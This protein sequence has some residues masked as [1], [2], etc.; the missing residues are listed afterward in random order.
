MY[1][2]TLGKFHS[3]LIICGLCVVLGACS[4][5]GDNGPDETAVRNWP[6]IGGDYGNRRFSALDQI[7]TANIGQVGGAWTRDLDGVVLGEPVV[8]NGRLFVATATTAYAL[9]GTTG[10]V[11]WSF[12]L[13][14][15]V[16][17]SYRGVGAGDEKI[18][19]G[20]GDGRVLALDEESGEQ[21]WISAPDSGFFPSG[22]SY[23]DGLVVGGLVMRDENARGHIL[24]LDA[25]DGEEVWRFATIPSEGPGREAWPQTPDGASFG[26]GNVWASGSFDL[27]L[28]LAYFSIASPSPRQRGDVREGANLFASSIVALDIETGDLQWHFQVT[29]HDI[30]DAGL[31]TPPILYD[32]AIEDDVRPAVAV[33]SPYGYLFQFDR[34]TGDPIWPIEARIAPQSSQQKTAQAQPFPIGGDNIGP[35]CVREAM[36]PSGFEPLCIYDPVD[37]DTPNA[38]Y[39]LASIHSAPL[40]YSPETKTFHAT[41]A[42]WPYWLRRFEGVTATFPEIAA[43][44]TQYAGLLAAVH[45]P[46]NSAVYEHEIPYRNQQRGAGL[47][48]TAGGLLFHGETDGFFSIYESDTGERI[49]RFQTGAPITQTAATYQVGDYQYVAVSAGNSVWAFR[50]DGSVEERAAPAIPDSQ[51]SF[52]ENIVETNTVTIS[53]PVGLTLPESVPGLPQNVRDEYAF[54]PRRIRVLVGDTVTWSNEGRTAKTI[55]AEDGAWTAGLIAPGESGTV[56]FDAPGTYTY[57]SEEYPFM[58]GQI[59]VEDPAE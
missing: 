36:I 20:L 48:A 58:L 12:E 42:I 33:I 19:V 25:D 14:A 50:I 40:A 28:G 2:V 32:I 10:A 11:L 6:V 5:S 7:N 24:A 26:G 31:R 3:A 38:M 15:Q 56:Q 51:A 55:A 43:P 45:G 49:W 8:S 37:F 27:E 16:H 9:N 34:E 59:F 1:A 53:P 52:S 18:F 39:P 13:P 4:Q 30:W 57:L 47:I 35:D 17:S 23:V 46:T 22:P 29:R 41:G 21:E 44:G 54:Y